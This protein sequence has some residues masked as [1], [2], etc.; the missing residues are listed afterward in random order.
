MTNGAMRRDGLESASF[1]PFLRSF[2]VAGL[3]IFSGLAPLDQC[4]QSPEFLLV[5][6]QNPAALD[7]RFPTL[8]PAAERPPLEFVTGRLQLV[9]K[10]GKPPFVLAEQSVVRTLVG[11]DALTLQ[12]FVDH[13]GL[14]LPSACWSVESFLVELLGDLAYGLAIG[15]QFLGAVKQRLQVAELF[16]SSHRA[17]D[18]MPALITAGPMNRHSSEL[19]VGTQLNRDT[20]DQAPHDLLPI[21]VGCA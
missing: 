12:E 15:T 13:R 14:D 1:W 9:S 19:A 11:N 8:D 6:P 3:T 17:N 7:R 4:A 18:L 10:I 20:F 21:D 5:G 2:Q 16:V